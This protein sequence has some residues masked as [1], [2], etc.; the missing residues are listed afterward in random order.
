MS[1]WARENPERYA[2]IATLPLSQQNTAL[3]DAIG[4]DPDRIC[5]GREREEP[6]P[7]KP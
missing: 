3:R 2:E 7:P 5:D 1:Q 4:Y 6:C